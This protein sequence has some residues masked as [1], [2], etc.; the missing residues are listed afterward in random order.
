M[1]SLASIIICLTLS[2]GQSCDVWMEAEISSF[3]TIDECH[4]YGRSKVPGLAKQQAIDS[5]QDTTTQYDARINCEAP[6]GTI[7]GI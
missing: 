4:A 6:K 5:G 2:T 3:N 7:K 1:I